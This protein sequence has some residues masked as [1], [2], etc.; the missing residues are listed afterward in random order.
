MAP[1]FP[2]GVDTS[3]VAKQLLGH[4]DA[5]TT[6]QADAPMELEPK[7]YYDP[8][9]AEQERRLIFTR[10]PLIGAHSSELPKA[11]DFVRTQ[12]PNNE[13]LLVRQRDGSVRGFVNSCRHR[14]ARLVEEPQGN[15]R[16]FSCRY[17][18]WAYNADGALRG[19]SHDNTFGDVDRGC[20]GLVELPVEE[21]HGFVWVVD[22]PTG[23]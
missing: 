21:R 20:L 7:G 16:V 2:V 8:D 5:K 18:G 12:L 13:V 23:T 17:H 11:H 1:K 4:V 3:V 22:K 14:G 15:H 10:V 19:I 9:V 6:D